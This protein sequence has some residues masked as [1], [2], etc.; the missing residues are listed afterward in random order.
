[1]NGKTLIS[2][3]KKDNYNLKADFEY[4]KE[5]NYNVIKEIDRGSYGVV[6]KVRANL[7]RLKTKILAGSAQ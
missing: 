7:N 4:L 3:N 6:Y 1:M 5:N 2:R